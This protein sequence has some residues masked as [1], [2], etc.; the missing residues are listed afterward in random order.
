MSNVDQVYGFN[1]VLEFLRAGKR[2]CRSIMIA[3]GKNECDG[4]RIIS[5]AKK[6][7]IKVEMVEKNL[8]N[9]RVRTDK[10]QG[11]VAEVDPYP[12]VDLDH[13]VRKRNPAQPGFVLI[14]DGIQDPQNLGSIIRTAHMMSIDLVIIPKDRSALVTGTVVKASAGATEYV[15]ISMVVNLARSIDALK[16]VGFWVYGAAGEAAEDLYRSD[17]K[18]HSIAIA[19]GAEGEGLRRLVR[20]RCDKLIAIPMSGA[21]GSFNVSVATALILGEVHRQRHLEKYANPGPKTA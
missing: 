18:G 17:F 3:R 20:E 9:D 6:R 13:A 5:E 11:V 7:G 15:D 19:M 2:R 1:P 21:V 4:E 14:L 8:L 16:E 12:Y 10:H